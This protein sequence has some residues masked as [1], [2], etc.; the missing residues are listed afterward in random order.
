MT[1]N[2]GH[3]ISMERGVHI[4][5]SGLESPTTIQRVHPDVL[6]IQLVAMK[7]EK[8]P[9]ANLENLVDSIRNGHRPNEPPL[10]VEHVQ[11]D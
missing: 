2:G 11:D 9:G 4:T 3:L 6:H 1:P 7:P 5:D 10:V 8:M